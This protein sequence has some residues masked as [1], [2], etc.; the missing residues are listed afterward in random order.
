MIASDHHF[1]SNRDTSSV[2]NVRGHLPDDPDL[3]A[4]SDLDVEQLLQ[5]HHRAVEVHQEHDRV[6]QHSPLLWAG[7]RWLQC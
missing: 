4:A 3:P 6:D 2:G 7:A 1:Q 5:G